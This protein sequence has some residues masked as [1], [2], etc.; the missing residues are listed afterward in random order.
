MNSRE[1]TLG[2]TAFAGSKLRNWFLNSMLERSDQ[3]QD[4]V[5]ID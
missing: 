2:V 1:V 3:V 4:S 5:R